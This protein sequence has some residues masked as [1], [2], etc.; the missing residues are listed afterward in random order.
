[1]KICKIRER[2]GFKTWCEEFVSDCEATT[3]KWRET[4]C[5]MCLKKAIHGNN[6]GMATRDTAKDVYMMLLEKGGLQ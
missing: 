1:M 6:I 3:K 5:T 2:N 4:N